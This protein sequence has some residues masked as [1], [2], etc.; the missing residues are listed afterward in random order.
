MAKEKNTEGV[1]ENTDPAPGA[2]VTV[3]TETPHP[4]DESSAPGPYAGL[5]AE[6]PPVSTTKPD[7]DV[8][9]SLA[10]GAGAHTPPD[11]VDEQLAANPPAGSDPNVVKAPKGGG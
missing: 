8:A 1:Q 5:N 6:R 7:V 11:N 10:A 9:Q 2:A 4:A 3:T